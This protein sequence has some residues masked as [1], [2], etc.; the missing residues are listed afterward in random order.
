[1]FKK[2][3]N[4]YSTG[5]RAIN[6]LTT[7]AFFFFTF[8]QLGRL[9]WPGQPVYFY[10]YEL[11]IYPILIIF[12]LKYKLE[13]FHKKRAIVRP[14]LYFFIVL[15]ISLIISF[16][17][18]TVTQNIVATLYLLRL[19]I[20]FMLFI[21]FNAY[22]YE[23]LELQRGF[24]YIVYIM[25]SI[26]IVTSLV[27]YF[28]YQDLGNI[29]YLG[30]DPHQ[31]RL[32]GL[33]FDPPLTVSVL[34]LFLIYFFLPIEGRLKYGYWIFS[35]VFCILAFLT[36]SRGGYMAFF[37]TAILYAIRRVPLKQIIGFILLV[38]LIVALLPKGQNESINLLRTTSIFTRARDYVI[39]F[40]IWRKN[41]IIGIGYNHI[42]YEKDRYVDE[43]IT[44][45]FNPSHASASFHSSFLM[46][47]VTGGVVGFLFYLWVLYAVAQVNEF[48]KYSVI[49]L[50]ILSLSDNVLLHPFILFLLFILTAVFMINP[51]PKMS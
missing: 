3:I 7:L 26:V 2:I 46:I 36:Y 1:M 5:S 38:A 4:F 14:I 42:R 43:P 16:F 41:P 25:A 6:I 20:Y 27:Q 9:S 21:Y 35:L 49:F 18:Y 22:I 34:I 39:G 15:T 32:V 47:L 40:E 45:A 23:Y 8:G 11:F 44:E 30:W 33:F 13:P 51:Y 37:I 31:Y 24:Q 29:A 28:L 19:F 48:A 12:F 10:I 17:F 50:S